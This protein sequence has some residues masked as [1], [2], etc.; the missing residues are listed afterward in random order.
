MKARAPVRE[1]GGGA[2]LEILVQPRASRTEIVG[3]HRDALKIRLAAPPVEGAANEAVQRF[4]AK[5]LGVPR[6]AVTIV[7]G[8]T[9]RRKAL[10]I[11]GLD[12]AEICRLL[13]LL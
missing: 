2:L 5:K 8:K 13:G 9:G 10:R 7:R 4:L 12:S 11:E 1:E 3:L 6:R